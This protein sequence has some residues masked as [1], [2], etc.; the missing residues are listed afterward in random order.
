MERLHFIFTML[1]QQHRSKAPVKQFHFTNST[2]LL[3]FFSIS[4]GRVLRFAGRKLLLLSFVVVVVV[5]VVV[6]LVVV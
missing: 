4:L 6:V 3:I 2:T 1:L 5:V